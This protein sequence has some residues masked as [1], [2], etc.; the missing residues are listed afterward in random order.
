MSLKISPKGNSSIRPWVRKCCSLQYVSW[1]WVLRSVKLKPASLRNS[2]WISWISKVSATKGDLI[3][4]LFTPYLFLCNLLVKYYKGV[5][6]GGG[7]TCAKGLVGTRGVHM[8]VAKPGCIRKRSLVRVFLS[9]TKMLSA[10][11]CK[12]P[13]KVAICLSKKS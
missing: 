5:S 12:H 6:T 10:V 4:L 9:I 8:K 7:V 3:T 13:H 11:K 1:I 2:S